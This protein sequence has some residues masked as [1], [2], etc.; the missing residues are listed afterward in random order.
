MFSG[1]LWGGLCQTDQITLRANLTLPLQ[2]IDKQG[3][4]VIKIYHTDI[5]LQSTPI[6]LSKSHNSIG[7]HND[8]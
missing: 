7:D 4:A 3:L 2:T 1:F 6:P 5:I 8:R